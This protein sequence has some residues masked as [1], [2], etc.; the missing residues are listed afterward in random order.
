MSFLTVS[1]LLNLKK[2]A[3]RQALWLGLILLPM[4]LIAGSIFANTEGTLITVNA[5]VFYNPLHPFEVSIFEALEGNVSD[6]PFINFIAYDNL[7]ELVADVRQ[8]RIECGYIL[9]PNI[10]NALYGE[11]ADIVTLITSPRTVAAPILNDIVTAAILDA[12]VQNITLNGLEVIFGESEELS[13]F[14]AWQF[15]AYSQM[16]IFMTPYFVGET[17][18]IYMEVPNIL[19]ITSIRIFHG[20]IG[21]TILILSLFC[22]PL[23]IEER[24]YGLK[25]ALSACRK[26]GLYELSLW[27]SAMTVMSVVGLSGLITM[28]IFTPHLLAPAFK[29]ITALLSYTAVCTIFLAAASRFLKTAGFIQSFSIFIVILNILFGGILLDLSELSPQFGQLQRLF[30]LYWYI[31]AVIY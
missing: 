27:A 20:L 3:S 1:F 2:F 5:G 8:G 12:A 25:A 29:S 11:L 10:E 22:T 30:P 9:N 16:D 18:D 31:N 24:H 15:E 14:V 17:G 6:N 19:E 21:L 4:T 23:F 28:Y 13:R 26:L 7:N